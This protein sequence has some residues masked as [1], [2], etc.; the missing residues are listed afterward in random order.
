MDAIKEAMIRAEDERAASMMQ[1]WLI[2]KHNL[3]LDNEQL[4]AAL[5]ESLMLQSHYAVLLNMQG[6]ERLTFPTIKSWLDRL[7]TIG[8]LP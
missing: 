7:K 1:K 6:G 5:Q 2:E 4:R 8:K 3:I